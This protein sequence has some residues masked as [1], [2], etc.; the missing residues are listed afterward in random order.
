MR[1]SSQPSTMFFSTSSRR[2]RLLMTVLG[3]VQ[4]GKFPLLGELAA[5][6]VGDDPL[7]QRAVVLKLQA[8]QRVGDA[9][10]G[11][12][13]GMGKVVQRVDAPLVALAVVG[14][15]LDAVDGRVAHVHVGAGQVDLG[16]QRL[17]AVG[18]LAGAHAAEQVQILLR[19]C[20][21]GRGWDGWACRRSLPRYSCICLAGQVVHIGLALP[22][23]A[24]R[25]TRSRSRK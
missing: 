11:V 17:F 19:G 12:L 21:P 9:L 14:H 24:F 8:A 13:D 1:G 22:G 20:G 23:S 3:H 18:K 10:D 15:M 25:R 16:A 2:Y 5:H 4:A 6:R 7:V